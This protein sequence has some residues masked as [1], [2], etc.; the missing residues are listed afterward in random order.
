MW[1]VAGTATRSLTRDCSDCCRWTPRWCGRISTRPAHR[2]IA[3]QGA[4]PNYKNRLAVEPDD[5][6]LGR[7][8]GGLSTKIHALTDLLTCAVAL[9]LTAVGVPFASAV[10]GVLVY[11]GVSFWL[12]VLPAVALLPT[13]KNL[14]SEIDHS[15][16]T[17][18]DADSERPLPSEAH[19]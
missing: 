12:P 10:L 6:A 8:R 5:H 7:S 9:S 19:S 18:R 14:R 2:R 3:T 4:D 17:E 11:R 1:C 15:T 16:R 13:A